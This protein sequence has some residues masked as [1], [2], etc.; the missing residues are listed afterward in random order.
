VSADLAVAVALPRPGFARIVAPVV[1]GHFCSHWFQYLLPP[2]FPLLHAAYGVGYVQLGILVTAFYIPS[3]VVQTF[4]GLVVDRISA[5]RVLA[6]GITLLAGSF[7]AIAA[8]PPFAALVPLAA[9]AGLGNSVFHPSN[10][11]ILNG[12]V[13][14]SMVGRAFAL[15]TLAGSLGYATAPIAALGL[16][17]R[18]SWQAA[19][20]VPAAL[21]LAVALY[22]AA[23]RHELNPS[24]VGRAAPGPRPRDRA[25]GALLQ[26]AVL[27]CFAFFA[28]GSFPGLGIVSALPATLGALFDTDAGLV[29]G[30]LSALLAGSG[31]GTII[32]GWLAD[33]SSRHERVVVCGLSAAAVLILLATTTPVPPFFLVGAL[34]LAGLATGLTTPS[35]D[36]LIRAAATPATIGR[37]FGFVY[38]GGDLGNALAPLAL[39]ALLDHHAVVWIVPVIVAG[40]GGMICAALAA[41][42][43][44]SA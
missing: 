28:I 27:A 6:C 16:A 21:A 22:I 35:R 13:A 30:A 36:M 7:L 1:I 10:F 5:P 40:Y 9:L 37:V 44:R 2:L 39:G 15:H 32:G 20:V 41:A 33:R 24:T 14:P 29:A 3:G 19:I 18:F 4:A 31:I 38:S 26:R 42:P 12:R 8:A 25:G 11:A 43:R 17:T 34:S 23:A